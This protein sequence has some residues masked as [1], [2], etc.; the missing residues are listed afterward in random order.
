MDR[1]M[2]RIGIIQI[3][4]ICLTIATAAI[5]LYLGGP[6]FLVNGLVYLALLAMLYM[7]AL[8]RFRAITR[9]GLIAFTVITIVFWVLYTRFAPDPIGYADKLIEVLLVGMLVLEMRQESALSK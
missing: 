4:V 1:S 2:A 5:H 6:L 9:I 7:P 8:R 3:G